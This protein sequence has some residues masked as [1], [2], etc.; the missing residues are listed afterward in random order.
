MKQLSL[1]EME[2]VQGGI[3]CS[4]VSVVLEY[5]ANLGPKYFAQIDA[6]LEMINSDGLQC[7]GNWY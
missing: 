2:V 5:L 1:N 3:M 7:E 6:I 4:E